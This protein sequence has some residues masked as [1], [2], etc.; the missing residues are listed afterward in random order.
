ME[1]IAEPIIYNLDYTEKMD[2]QYEIV[3]PNDERVIFKFPTV[4][5]VHHKKDSKYTVYVG[6]TTDIKKRTFQHLKVDI[7]SRED[8]L[9]FSEE[10]D[11]RMFVIGH[12][13]FNKSLTLD[14]ENKLMHYLSSTDTV[15]GV[16]NR[17][18]N[19][20]NEYYTSDNMET[21][22][23]KIWR[24]LRSFEP[25]IFP[26]RKR[27]E[28]TAVFKASPFHK[29]T[30]EQINA[31]E[32]IM[33]RIV[34]NIA[35][36]ISNNDVESKLIMVNGEAG[37]GKTVLMSNLFYELFQ[38]SSLGKNETVLSGI[39]PYLLVNHDQQLKVYK[40]IAK[41]LG[42]NKKGE[43]NLVQKPT[44]FI[45]NHSPENKLD[46]VIV[47]EAH[48][49][50]TQGKQSYRGKN[51][52]LDL[53][54]RAKVVVIVFDENQILLTE[55]VWESEYLDKLK[56]ECNL[57]QN[58][59]ELKNQMRIH[60]G[61]E[62]V[63]WIRNIIDNNTIGDIP[64]DSK[65]Y[66][67]KIFNSPSEMEKE[68]IRRNNNEDMGLSRMVAT[69]DWEYSQN[70]APEGELWKVTVG[71]WSMPWNF[72]LLKSK[73]KKTK[74]SKKSINDNSLAWAENPK[75]I[76]EIGSTF[77]VQGFDLN[78]VGVII[79]PS[80]SFKDGKVVFLPENSKNKKAVRNRTFDS[81]NNKPKKQKFGETLLKNE[82]NVL[83]T[84]GV[85]GLYIYA[86]DPDLQNELLRRQ[87][88]K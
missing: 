78:Y 62:T 76:E 84:R 41:K 27:I 61:Q 22:F 6:E 11:V 46:V 83:L 32:Q 67:L 8:W 39:T 23:S 72:E 64:I 15:S 75:S 70:N 30:Q 79:G 28:D 33:L 3:E 2:N 25:D 65:G 85:K 31:K 40:E 74:K 45:N 1:R 9:N 50:L 69:Y 55:Q 38:E 71:D 77:S 29:L 87:G 18:L 82:L 88:A 58:Y 17:R 56:H 60:S 24:K 14:I 16:N 12:E 51:Q 19:Q 34:S 63:R 54:E 13:M 20:Q 52:L 10:S 4:Y 44:S 35:N 36:S 43:E 68:I 5:I 48:L 81:E 37:S 49:L 86:V 53:L 21:I 47:D 73:Y 57:N 42:I 7:K 59:I 26:T 66:D 80:V